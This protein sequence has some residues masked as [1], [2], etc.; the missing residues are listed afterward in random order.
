MNS[1]AIY[2]TKLNYEFKRTLDYKN[3]FFMGSNRVWV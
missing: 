3:K 2:Y 1:T